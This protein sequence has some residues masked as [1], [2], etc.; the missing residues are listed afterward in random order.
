VGSEKL[1][2]SDAQFPSLRAFW[3]FLQL[4]G[5]DSLIFEIFLLEDQADWMVRLSAELS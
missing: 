1:Y 2:A 4:E 5:L 3:V